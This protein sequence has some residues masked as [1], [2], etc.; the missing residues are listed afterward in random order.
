LKIFKLLVVA[1]GL[2]CCGGCD[3]DDTRIKA[4]MTGRPGDVAIFMPKSMHEGPLGTAVRDSLQQMLPWLAQL[5]QRFDPSFYDS[6]N[7]ARGA[8]HTRNIIAFK[9]EPDEE[10]GIEVVEDPP[11]AEGQYYLVIRGGSETELLEIFKANAGRIMAMLEAEEA[12]RIAAEVHKKPA[13][14]VAEDIQKLMG[15]SIEVPAGKDDLAVK[16]REFC[17]IRMNHKRTARNVT[18][19]IQQGVF[20]YHY[21]Y[22]DTAQFSPERILA[23][24]DSMLR[25]YVPGPE[26]KLPT[27]M[28]TTP[29][30]LFKPWSRVYEKDGAYTME[31]R[32]QWGITD[33]LGS[34]YG[35]GGPFVCI[36]VH[37]EKYGRIVCAE[38]YLH[39]PEFSARE[40]MRML[41]VYV[42]TLKTGL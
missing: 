39:A 25:K 15:V 31:V 32:S 40:Y 1:A 33:S 4:D 5:E 16:N 12:R 38:G 10:P 21:P 7:V 14:S 24:R 41:E 29:D 20:V 34:F 3:L 8:E 28:R 2:V 6:E 35:M 22:T 18:H 19:V 30:S 23:M 11:F 13:T 17:W 26:H 42:K 9:I 37:D 27:Y 36:A